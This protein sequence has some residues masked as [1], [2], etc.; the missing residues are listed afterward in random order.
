MVILSYVRISI[1]III[2]P[3]MKV[4]SLIYICLYLMYLNIF[5]IN[6]LMVYIQHR[7]SNI[8]ICML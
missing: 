1:F 6:H 4:V 2:Y 8:N 7:Y 3:S 5:N